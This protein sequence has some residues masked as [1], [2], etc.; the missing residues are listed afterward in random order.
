MEITQE[1]ECR[2]QEIMG[3]MQCPR[4]FKCYKSGFENLGKVRIIGGGKLVECLEENRQPC[5][6]GFVFGYG[7]FCDCPL[8]KYIAEN[9]KV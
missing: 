9:F 3:E 8:R 6:L 7:Y 5:D 4:D 2:I 1:H